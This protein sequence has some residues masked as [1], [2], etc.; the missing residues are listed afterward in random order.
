MDTAKI[1]E[2][3]RGQAVLLPERFRFN[4][5]EV[6]IRQL[7]NAVVLAPK[8]FVWQTFLS[9]LNAVSYTHLDV[10]KR[11]SKDFDADAIC[12]YGGFDNFADV[13]CHCDE[14]DTLTY[15]DDGEGVCYFYYPPSM[16][17]HRVANEPDSEEEVVERIIR[18]VQ[19]ITDMS[20]SEI[21]EPVSYTHL[22]VY[23]RQGLFDSEM[24]EL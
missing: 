2:S 10:Y 21:R 3:E 23:K 20:R 17:W 13:L 8:E 7:G 18:A 14:T 9:G 15:G 6:V 1:F 16:P 4:T 5:D 19:K 11:Q 22:D 12:D 24:I